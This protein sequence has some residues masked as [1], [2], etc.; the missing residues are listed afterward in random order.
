MTT[1]LR[2]GYNVVMVP[3]LAQA[4]QRL[5][6]VN[7]F[8]AMQVTDDGLT[9]RQ[10]GIV[11]PTVDPT[12]VAAAGGSVNAGTHLIR[13]RYQD[14]TR[15]RLSN[16]SNAATITVVA[17]TQ[18][19]NIG[20][21]ASPDAYVT[22]IIIEMTPVGASTY[23]RVAIPVNATASSAVTM[24]DAALIVQITAARDGEFQHLPPGLSAIVAEHRQRVW[25]WGASKR[26]FTGCTLTNAS[27]TINGVGFS[28]Q[29]AGR[30]VVAPDGLTYV[31][32]SATTIAITLATNY[33]GANTGAGTITVKSGT[34]SLLGWSRAGFPESFDATVFARSITL[35]AGD[36]PAA[37]ASYFSDMYLM[38]K[39]SMRRL[40]FTGD[41]AS[42][43][44][45]S[46]P[47][48]MGAFHQRCVCSAGAGLLF[49]WGRDGAWKV[50]AMQPQKIS[51]KVEQ[52][53]ALLA[54][55]TRINER[56][57]CYEP[58]QRV[59]QFFFCL[60]G[61]ATCRAALAHHIESGTWELWRYR[62]GMLSACANSSYADRQRLMLADANGY[63]WR[64]GTNVNDGAD[65]G[66]MT[67][68][69]GAT[70]TVIPGA[71]SAIVGQI[72]YR[73]ATSEERLIT[74]ASPTQITTAA[75]ATAPAN[76]EA[77][78]IGSVRQRILTDW[79]V[80]DGLEA[81]QRPQ[82]LRVMLR[83]TR[84]PGQP[85]GQATVRFYRDFDALTPIVVTAMSAD[86]WPLGVQP[87]DGDT[88]IT[89]DLDAGGLDGFIPVPVPD[90][91]SRAVCAEIIHEQPCYP[92][93]FYSLEFAADDRYATADAGNE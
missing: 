48:T 86:E 55:A 12:P 93:R 38:G 57:I 51:A 10:A 90:G 75:F 66:T 47:G 65:L 69:A 31:I 23:Y 24:N 73:P 70:T 59:V 13:Y 28:T 49:G 16:P 19:L 76:G 42:G 27:P 14:Q 26:I 34:P 60:A 35:D 50:D 5:Y 36:E 64:M 22:H 15:G 37:M 39:R 20:V 63:S 58:V 33:A 17:G 46:V 82:W 29:W 9:M 80:G 72:A 4:F 1:A 41:P 61:E 25:T 40:V 8:D 68:T 3:C 54:D 53:L 78:Y 62:Q 85:M 43:M 84:V 79:F 45:L 91:W 81:K 21:T 87:L 6:V 71:N 56:F 83:A 89:I 88:K 32:A 7:D 92:V 30:Q 67:A 74:A 52:T 2:A 18:T 77:I 11:A 44:L